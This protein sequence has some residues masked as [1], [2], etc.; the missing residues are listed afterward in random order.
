[1][2]TTVDQSAALRVL[3]FRQTVLAAVIV[4]GLFFYVVEDKAVIKY[5]HFQVGK[6][7]SALLILRQ[8]FPV[9]DSVIGDVADCSADKSEFAV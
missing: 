4:E 5:A 1:M 2:I 6:P 7:R 9:A 8:S 3:Q